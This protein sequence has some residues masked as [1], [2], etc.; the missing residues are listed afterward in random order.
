[1]IQLRNERS[2]MRG[3]HRETSQFMSLVDGL[4]A[5][6]WRHNKTTTASDF[7][8]MKPRRKTFFVPQL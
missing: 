5:Q 3:C 1:M 8:G 7:A 4:D 6:G 2:S